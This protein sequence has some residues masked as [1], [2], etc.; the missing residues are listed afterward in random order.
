MQDNLQGICMFA[1]NTDQID[2]LKLSIVAALYAKKYLP[3]KNTCLI[4][5]ASDVTWLE[6]NIEH[7]IINAAFDEIVT[8]SVTHK[9]NKRHHSDT[10]WGN[11]VSEFKN[12][13]KHDI[14]ELSPYDQT[15]LIDI[16]FFIQNSQFNDLFDSKIPLALYKTARD[17]R[18]RMPQLSEQ[19]LDP[20][21]IPM[22]WST[23][24]YFDKSDHSKMFFELWAHIADNYDFYRHRYKLPNP[25]FRTDFCVSIAAHI[26]GGFGLTDDYICE[27][28]DSPMMYS[29]QV[30]DIIEVKSSND[31]IFL[32]NDLK[33]NWKDI[34]VR[35]G[36]ENIHVMNKRAI[37]RHYDRY[38]E[39]L[40]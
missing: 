17:L 4:T 15:L 38:L 3:T 31:T 11:F 10:P 12:S 23:A 24:I 33:E 28:P 18:G 30:D 37:E 1:Y 6:K 25:L 32:S 21:G 14:F 26:L 39:V 27:L 34:I 40:L 22:Y 16:D 5:T 7:H 29:D 35:P 9:P 36:P 8:S 2:Y 19:R 13:N 20:A